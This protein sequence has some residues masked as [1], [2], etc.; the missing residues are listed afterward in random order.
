MNTTATYNMA[1]AEA[2]AAL[3]KHWPAADSRK[4]HTA[5]AALVGGLLRGGVSR[6]NVETIVEAIVEATGDEEGPKR[7]GLVGDT[8]AKLAEGK[9]VTGWP[10]L[11]KLL[12]DARDAVVRRVH[13][14][15]GIDGRTVAATYDYCD[16]AGCRRFQT[17]RYEP[18]DFHQRRPDGKGGWVWNLGG[19]ECLLYRLPELVNADPG[20]TVYLPEGE[21][22]VDNLRALGLVATCNPMGAGKWQER[23]N[24]P[25]RHRHVVILPDNDDPG[26]EHAREVAASLNG[27]AASVKVLELPGLPPGG[28]VSDWL[29]NGGTAEELRRLAEA[30][31][32]WQG[33]AVPAEAAAPVLTVDLPWPDRLGEEALHSLPGDIVRV[34]EPASEADP[35]ALLLQTMIGFGNLIGR[36]AH[37]VVEAD[38]HHANE[39]AVLVGKTS[40]ARKGTSWGRVNSLLRGAE[41]EWAT[42]RVQTGLSSGEGLIWGVRDPIM[43]RERIKEQ[44]EVRYEEVEADPG[45]CDKRL[46]IVEPEFANVLKQTERQGNTLSAVLRQAWEGG[47]LRSLTKNSPARAT[48]AH[49]SLIG[50]I[51]AEELR[52][53]LSAT[54]QA[55]G[56]GNR[57][58]WV[59]VKRSKALPEGGWV[60]EK[61]L[62]DLQARLADALA[63]ARRAGRMHR[64]EEAR[65][66]WREVYGPL[67]AE[68]PGLTG[69]ML[70]R[71]EAHVL[72]LSLVY[73]LMDG[74]EFIRAPHLMAALALWEYCEQSVRHV[75][76]DALGDPVADA[77]A[78]QL[79]AA[80]DGMSRSE[81]SKALGHNVPS[82]RIGH[83]LALLAEHRLVRC[84]RRDTGGRP[85]ERWFAARPAVG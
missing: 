85:E 30:A 26:R 79:R 35:V 51:T 14:L 48:G 9:N 77:L 76:G 15:L 3:V 6:E 78:R 43:K 49:I 5:F 56:F 53:Y 11:A 7:L 33:G 40:K 31:G 19:V 32:P 20:E 84:E 42:K 73:A 8:A 4:R 23:F 62:A 64:D 1:V 39:F 25:L 34:L 71:A 83:A 66:I 58:L 70:G 50:H 46:L 36:T 17:V 37:F 27:L 2:V 72:R 24:G 54:E 57:H 80:P 47:D 21:K 10:T 29:A 61:A 69:A 22:D 65:E 55:N 75:F 18:K 74:S 28:D 68:R 81:M 16:E 60:D 38:K 59:C 52:R 63:T 13:E 45:E 82:V 41:E 44:G 12:G 67:S